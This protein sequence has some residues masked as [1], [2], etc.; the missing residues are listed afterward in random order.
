[1][2]NTITYPTN[3]NDVEN[4]PGEERDL[5]Y[6]GNFPSAEMHPQVTPQLFIETPTSFIPPSPEVVQHEARERERIIADFRE[7]GRTLENIR[8]ATV[9]DGKLPNIS[10]PDSHE[11]ALAA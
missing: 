10:R 5:S 4:R 6:G 1:M 9:A 2:T 11:Y 8:R 7:A 3:R